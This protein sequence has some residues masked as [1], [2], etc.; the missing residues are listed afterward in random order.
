MNGKEYV[1]IED[2]KIK[3]DSYRTFLFC[4]ENRKII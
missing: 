3:K 4:T 1:S 2:H